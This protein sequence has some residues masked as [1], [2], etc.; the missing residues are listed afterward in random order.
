VKTY[1]YADLVLSSSLALP[2]LPAAGA[3]RSGEAA[4]AFEVTTS[5]PPEPEACRWVDFPDGDGRDAPPAVART[6]GGFL[7][8]FPAAADFLISADA[9]RVVCSPHGAQAAEAIRHL[10]LDQVLPRVVAH[11]GRLVLHA[12]AV[13]LESATLAIVGTSGVGK[14]TLIAGFHRAGF[15]ALTDDGFIVMVNDTGCTGLALYTGLRLW[16]PSIAGLDI[17]PAETEPM[18]SRSA[19]RRVRLPAAGAPAPEP[20]IALFVLTPP[21][22]E[23]EVQDVTIAPLSARDACV[24]LLRASFQLDIGNPQG[25]AGHLENAALVAGRL[26]VFALSYPRDYALLP[27]VREAILRCLEP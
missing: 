18:D 24:E 21:P 20:L 6:D 17:D 25:A 23:D 10:L 4:I 26:P 14:S 22:N 13:T 1:R 2:E 3:R 16:P 5:S 9:T 15:H 7:L 11:L 12:G 8:R 27:R 19:K